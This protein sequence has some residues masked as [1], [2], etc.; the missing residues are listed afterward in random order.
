[1]PSKTEIMRSA[2]GFIATA[3]SAADEGKAWR[4]DPDYDS[5][6]GTKLIGPNRDEA[7]LLDFGHGDDYQRIEIQGFYPRD[8]DRS[9]MS[10]E[11]HKISVGRTRTPD[12]VA[13]EIMRRFLPNYRTTLADLHA[14]IERNTE[15][16]VNRASVAV[17]LVNLSGGSLHNS[18]PGERP[19]VRV[20]L[21]EGWAEFLVSSA[22]SIT[23]EVKYSTPD[24]MRKLAQVL[25]EHT[26]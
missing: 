7:V 11:N 13:R 15:A 16:D 5:T 1:M 10:H 19:T 21:P 18:A 14:R 9:M 22:D 20:D 25:R 23:L 4:A 26:A 24:L 12:A 2:T 8:Y 6:W 3:L 17:D